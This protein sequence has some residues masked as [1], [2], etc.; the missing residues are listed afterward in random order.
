ML[1]TYNAPYYNTALQITL[2]RLQY[3]AYTKQLVV[4]VTAVMYAAYELVSASFYL[5][6]C[7]Y[8]VI[9]KGTSCIVYLLWYNIITLQHAVVQHAPGG[10]AFMHNVTPGITPLAYVVIM[11]ETTTMRN[12]AQINGT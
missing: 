6:T 12:A 3:I 10:P 5:R 4:E 1:Y 7:T 11:I 8:E 2:H 9:W